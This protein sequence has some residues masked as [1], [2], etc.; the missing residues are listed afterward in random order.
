[1][2]HSHEH[3]D[4]IFSLLWS[5]ENPILV[6][7]GFCDLVFR[8]IF[9]HQSL[10]GVEKWPPMVMTTVEERIKFCDVEFFKLALI[11]MS[12]DSGS[13]TFLRDKK[14]KRKADRLFAES[15]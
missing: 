13:Y 7:G 4:K 12:N 1:M 6:R 15:N 14:L 5:E 2:I 10:H 11:L 9:F 8:L 3:L